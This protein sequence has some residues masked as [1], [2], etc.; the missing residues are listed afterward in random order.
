MRS[1]LY[2]LLLLVFALGI[3]GCGDEK[4]R[5]INSNKERPR[6]ADKP[7]PGQ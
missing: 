7:N 5:G 3:L 4:N 1:W 2:T 6:A